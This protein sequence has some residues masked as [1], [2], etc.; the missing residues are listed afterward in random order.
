[1]SE[2]EDASLVQLISMCA[3]EGIDEDQVEAQ[4]QDYVFRFQ[5]EAITRRVEELR[6]QQQRAV[7]AGR[8]EEV[9]SLSA[10][11]AGLVRTRHEHGET[12]SP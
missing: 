5:Q 12:D 9:A 4:W 8:Q 1:M 7:A 2:I 10:E 6:Q 3:M 11:I